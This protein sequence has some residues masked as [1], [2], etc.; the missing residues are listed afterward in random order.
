MTRDCDGDRGE[1][2]AT[3][4]H[5]QRGQR[6]PGG[7]A[8]G[9]ARPGGGAEAGS[10]RGQEGEGGV[11]VVEVGLRR[12]GRE[13]RGVGAPGP[14][15]GRGKLAAVDIHARVLLL[16]FCPPV[17][18]PDLDLGLGE[19]E[20]EREVEAL[21]HREVARRLEL[22]LEADQLLVCEGRPRA[23]RLASS[24]S[25]LPFP[26]MAIS[27][28]TLGGRRHRVIVIRAVVIHNKIRAVWNEETV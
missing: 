21:A 18:E 8:G 25:R 12:P 4:V 24:I 15:P 5:Q 16:P 22:V 17:L 9:V 23:P 26:V 28:E 20:A 14:G 27:L 19:V 3:L 7:G 1:A 13:Q 6:G 11:W 10:R 2:Q